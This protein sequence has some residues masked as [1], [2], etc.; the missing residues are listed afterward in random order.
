MN[1]PIRYVPK[2]LTRKD[3]NK[4]LA[5]LKRSRRLY[6]HGKYYTRKRVKS[7]KSR[8]SNHLSRARSLYGV[9]KITPS[10]ELA[11][12]SG[13]SVRAL[14]KIVNKG[15]GAY[16]SSGSRPNQTAQ[17]WGLARLAS[18]LT[19]GKAS[20]VDYHILEDGCNSKFIR[21]DKMR[22]LNIPNE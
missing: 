6:K 15:E 2:N 17:S 16:Y 12:A 21:A 20:Y 9:D 18:A 7:F 1:I 8:K 11:T 13:C 4:Q 3:R 5:M 22:K 19:S 10:Q 14:E